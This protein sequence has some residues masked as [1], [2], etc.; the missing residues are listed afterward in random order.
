MR[1][2]HLFYIVAG[3]SLFGSALFAQAPTV[4]VSVLGEQVTYG[5]GRILCPNQ[6]VTDAQI[7]ISIDDPDGDPVAVVTTITNLTTQGINLA[8]W[9][10]TSAAVPH[11]LAPT[12]GTFNVFP[13]VHTIT[14]TADDGTGN[15][16]IFEFTLAP[17][18]AGDCSGPKKKDEQSCST[19]AHSSVTVALLLLTMAT[20][21]ALRWYP[22]REE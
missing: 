4:T 16:T 10:Q 11:V 12:T 21:A 6:E 5:G 7:V 8:E 17:G 19:A 15:Q 13:I 1:L 22:R 18:A 3:L 20:A 2:L 9:S 14:I